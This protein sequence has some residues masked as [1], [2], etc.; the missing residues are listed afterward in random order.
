MLRYKINKISEIETDKLLNFYKKTYNNR[1]KSLTNNW[2]WWYRTDHSEFEPLILSVDEQVVGQAGLLPVDLNVLGKK[3]KAIWFVDFA[4]LPKFQNQGFGKIL[5]KEWMKIC[6]NQIT[7]CK[8]LSLKIFKKIGW[9]NSLFEKRYAKPINVLKI[10]PLLNKLNL[11]LINNGLRYFIKKKYTSEVLSNPY[12]IKDNFK[13]LND[14]FKIKK[15]IDNGTLAE[16]IRDESWLYWRLMKCPYIKDIYFFEYKNNFAIVH[17]FL[18]RN[19][20]KLNIL[21][22]YSTDNHEYNELFK[23]IINW[24]I[25]NNID[26]LWAIGR[27]KE[28]ANYFS[29]ILTKSLNFASWSSDEK[30]FKVLQ[31]G[32]SDPQAIDSDIDS[33]LYIE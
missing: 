6:S 30:I 16:I 24:S 22:T 23:I 21:Y 29:K 33:S 9:K 3:V 8:D 2:R 27:N 14:S 18:A 7:F 5:T 15:N 32:L 17:I 25:N 19:I 26:Y 4:I 20:K 12:N 11:N 1:Y 10:K 28:L 31:N 13:V